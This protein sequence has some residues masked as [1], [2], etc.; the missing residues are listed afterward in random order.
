METSR[1]AFIWP[2]VGPQPLNMVNMG[3]GMRLVLGTGI[4]LQTTHPATHPVYPPRVHPCPP[5]TST[6]VSS[7]P[8]RRAQCAVGLKSV[9]Q[10]SL[11]IHISDIRGMTEVYNVRKIGRINNH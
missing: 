11:S 9:G 3:P 4:A 10:L 7:G 6:P 5:R 2:W 1:I 8:R